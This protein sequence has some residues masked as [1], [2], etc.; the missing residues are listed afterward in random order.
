MNVSLRE[1]RLVTYRVLWQAGAPVGTIPAIVDA[2][3]AAEGAGLGGFAALRED[4]DALGATAARPVRVVGDTRAVDAA[5][6]HALALAPDVLDLAV[7]WARAEGTADLEVRGA[8]RPE[9]L[10]VLTTL[11]RDHG[12]EVTARTPTNGVHRFTAT[13][14]GAHGAGWTAAILHHGL[15]VPE[16]LWWH[17]FHLGNQA[18][19]PDSA[20][21]RRH[22]GRS[23]FDERGRIVGE[24]GEDLDSDSREG[25]R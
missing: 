10:D 11:A 9:L 2:V 12:V 19:T 3:V 16:P 4:V 18:L 8:A 21:S 13:S 15:D 23:V 22:T 7:A 25:Q 14:A 6:K 20:V 5:G 24:I 17:L 1:C